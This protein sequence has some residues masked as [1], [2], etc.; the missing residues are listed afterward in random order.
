MS[1][2]N[3]HFVSYAQDLG[4]HPLVAA[5]G[6]S[7]VGAAAIIGA[8]WLGHLSDK[9]GR[10]RF[11]ALS[12]HVRTVGFVIV[13]LSMGVSF[14]GIPPLGITALLVGILLVGFSWSAVVSITAAYASDE[15]GITNLGRIYGTMFAVMPLGMGLGSSLGGLLYD[16]RGTYDMAI[17][18]NVGLLIVSTLLVFSIDG[19]T[20]SPWKEKQP[21]S[22]KR[23]RIKPADS[24]K[25]RR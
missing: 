17:W 23:A 7:L 19:K 14:L 22:P 12:Y 3:A 15:F 25:G 16:V 24:F 1:F 20:S 13:L 2:V 5:S 18:S 4:Y 9:H 11:L 6:F 10:R 8:L 21:H